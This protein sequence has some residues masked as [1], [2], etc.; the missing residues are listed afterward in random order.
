MVLN[1]IAVVLLFGIPALFVGLYCSTLLTMISQEIE[2]ERTEKEKKQ[3][4]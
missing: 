2:R 4:E 3:D 1:I